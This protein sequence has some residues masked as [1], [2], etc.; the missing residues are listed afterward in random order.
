MTDGE[1]FI[2]AICDAPHDKEL[3][4]VYGDWLEEN[5]L[6]EPP[7]VEE[8]LRVLH[9]LAINPIDGANPIWSISQAANEWDLTGLDEVLA[10]HRRKRELL[11]FLMGKAATVFA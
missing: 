7:E 3:R 1:A 10:L 4:L 5:G 9:A 8:L 11:D 6:S 2:R